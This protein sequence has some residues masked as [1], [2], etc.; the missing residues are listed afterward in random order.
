M[1]TINERS[2]IKLMT[3][4]LHKAFEIVNR[5]F[6]NNELPMPAITIQ[7]SGKRTLAMGWCTSSP[8]WGDKQGE[9]RMY[10]INLS[11]EYIDVSFI[12]TMDTLMHEMVHLYN[13]IKGIQDVS[14]N[15]TYHNKKFKEQALK[16]GFIHPADKP[17]KK[18]GYSFVKLSPTTIA[19]L[20][21]LD[22]NQSVFS[23]G[24]KTNDY[25]QNLTDG[26]N[27]DESD[28]VKSKTKGFRWICPNCN[29]ILRSSKPNL[30][31]ICGDCQIRL[32]HEEK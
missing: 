25:F 30:N 8:I 18:Y 6:Y 22:I 5:K 13:L 3:D 21:E 27:N 24:R 9:Q 17:D 2:N 10:E 26:K 7:S 14:R 20:N 11:A 29:M 4:E 15:G 1:N 12:E 31:I 23:I 28:E 32:V 19:I 16:S